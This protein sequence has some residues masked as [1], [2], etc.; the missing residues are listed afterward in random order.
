MSAAVLNPPT[1]GPIVPSVPPPPAPSPP[2][3]PPLPLFF[4]R[5]YRFTV[6]KYHALVAAGVLTRDTKCELLEGYLVNKMPQDPPHGGSVKALNRRIGRLLPDGWT[7]SVQSP[8]TLAD[9][10]PEPDVAVVRGDDRTYFRRHPGPTDFG[11]VIEVADS[12]LAYDR[13]DKGRTYA[14]AGLPV[15]WIV[16]LVEGRLEVYTDPRPAADPPGYAARTDYTPGQ[17]VPLTLAGVEVAAV[18]VADLLP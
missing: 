13:R 18:P 4:D 14:R 10:E 12:S 1:A 11:V 8:I 2:A 7:L 15:Y 5:L 3:A 17:A 16:N 9:G 6:E